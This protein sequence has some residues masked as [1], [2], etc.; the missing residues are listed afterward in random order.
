MANERYHNI[1]VRETSEPRLQPL[2]DNLLLDNIPPHILSHPE[3]QSVQPAT[4][5]NA[6]HIP[7]LENLPIV[8][9]Q[10]IVPYPFSR[11]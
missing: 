10:L 2:G 11:Q 6:N 8:H 4:N 5:L 9:Q 7:A 1:T 3:P